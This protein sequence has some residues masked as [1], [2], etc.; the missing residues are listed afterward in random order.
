MFWRE[1][2]QLICELTGE[3]VPLEA[4]LCL[5]HIY[6]VNFVGNARKCKLIDFCLL[7]AKPVIALKWKDIQRPSFTQWVE[8]MFCNLAMEKLTYTVRGKI[9][10]F[11]KMWIHLFYNV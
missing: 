1:V 7:Q 11:N 3:T 6:P 8:E 5:L 10:E 9:E 2:F 4:K